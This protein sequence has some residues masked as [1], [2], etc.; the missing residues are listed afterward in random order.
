MNILV[1]KP[2]SLGDILHTFPA[3]DLL[4]RE[5]PDAGITWLVNDNFAG[6]IDLLPGVDEV[7]LFRRQRWGRMR[8]WHECIPFVRD[9]RQRGFDL[10]IDFQ[11]LL[12]SALLAWLSGAPARIGFHSARECGRMFY[13]EK[14]MVPANLNHAVDRNVF[15]V[16][17][18]LRLEG[19]M[20][21]PPLRQH[22]DFVKFARQLIQENRLDAGQG[23]LAVA[24][25]A[26]WASKRWPA[27]SFA[28]VIDGVA[29]ERPETA[30]WL[31]GSEDERGLAEEVRAACRVAAP[32]N[33]A[34]KTNLGTLC[35]MLR[36]SDALLTNDSGPMHLAAALGVPTVAIF[37][38]TSAALTGP[39][40]P[41]HRVFS[42]PCAVG[43]CFRRTCP[44]GERACLESIS[45]KKVTEAL[46]DVLS[47]ETKPSLSGKE[48]V[49]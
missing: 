36:A 45:S 30:V 49:P 39:Y 38:P 34:G 22:H 20:R 15:L 14:V 40:G 16:Q 27:E 18:G 26:R 31:L 23:V 19:E 24:P 48:M 33:L 17:S 13:T 43:P 44:Q 8:H 28:K 32:A 10:A 1:V 21:V 47:G 12:R 7:I 5:Y 35:E 41:G 25:G 42:A 37:G 3:V 11:G 9:L 6:L 46:L 29:Q 2:S 4:R